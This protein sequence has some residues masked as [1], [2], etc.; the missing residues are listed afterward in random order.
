[1]TAEDPDDWQAVSEK[2]SDHTAHEVNRVRNDKAFRGLM[3]AAVGEVDILSLREFA[4]KAE[5]C[6]EHTERGQPADDS[7]KQA[8]LS[9]TV[10]ERQ[11]NQHDLDVGETTSNPDLEQLTLSL[12]ARKS[13]EATWPCD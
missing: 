8:W 12:H 2:E 7:P 5:V 10:S 9:L 6:V 4:N 3:I 1:M 13:A 11:T